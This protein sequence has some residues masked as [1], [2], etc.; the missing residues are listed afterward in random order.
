MYNGAVGTA[1]LLSGSNL[2]LPTS[3]EPLFAS[4]LVAGSNLLMLLDCIIPVLGSSF[5]LGAECCCCCGGGSGEIFSDLLLFIPV[6]EVL[7]A[8]CCL[9]L[10]CSKRLL[11]PSCI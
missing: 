5:V 8:E 3:P 2:L 9:A 7:C 6:L 4:M 1:W 11:K 10:A